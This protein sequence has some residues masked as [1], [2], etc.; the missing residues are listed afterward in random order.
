[1]RISRLVVQYKT[2]ALIIVKNSYMR[3]VNLNNYLIFF[4]ILDFAYAFF[5]LICEFVIFSLTCHFAIL[6]GYM[7]LLMNYLEI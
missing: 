4:L 5:M 7:R 3:D 6:L 1:M 2:R